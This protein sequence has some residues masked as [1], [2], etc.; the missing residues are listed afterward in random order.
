MLEAVRLEEGLRLG[1]EKVEGCL[2]EVVEAGRGRYVRF[3]ARRAW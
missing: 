2:R 1:K 3:R